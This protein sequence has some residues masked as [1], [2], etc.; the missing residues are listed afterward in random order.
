MATPPPGSPLWD[1]L[2]R[3]FAE[4]G[5]IDLHKPFDYIGAFDLARPGADRT[6]FA[7]FTWPIRK[8]PISPD[9]ATMLDDLGIEQAPRRARRPTIISITDVR[10]S[11]SL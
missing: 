1:D 8:A 7:R 3:R 2:R 10:I 11:R 5:K 6:S 4:G 9:M